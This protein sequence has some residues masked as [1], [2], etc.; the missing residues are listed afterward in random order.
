MS[1]GPN[2]DEKNTRKHQSIRKST[3]NELHPQQD[4]TLHVYATWIQHQVYSYIYG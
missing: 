2:R 3:G 4:I 1:F